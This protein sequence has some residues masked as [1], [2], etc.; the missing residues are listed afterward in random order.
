[1]K[2]ADHVASRLPFIDALKALASQ[3]IV[4]H[5]LA[6]YGPM[7]D[8]VIPLAPALVSWFADYARLAV[9]AFLVIAGFLGASALASQFSE[10]RCENSGRSRFPGAG[11][12]APALE[13]GAPPI[14][15]AEPLTVRRLAL[16][17]ALRYRRLALPLVAAVALAILAAGIVRPW[18]QHPSVPAA[19]TLAQLIA[20][21][22]L[23]HDVVGEEALSA[24]IWYVAIDLQ[25]FGLLL[26]ALWVGR[27]LRA[28][29]LPVFVLGVASLFVF[30]LDARWDV[31][32]PYFFGAYS[33]G[34]FAWHAQAAARVPLSAVL[35]ALAA[36]IALALEF[37]LRIAVALTIATLL[38]MAGR[39]GVLQ[40]W[41]RGRMVEMLGRI[42]YS[43]FLVHFPVCLLVNA[44]FVQFAGAHPFVNL[45]GV[46]LAWAT[47][48]A[49]GA[50]FYQWVERPLQR[51]MGA[52]SGGRTA[53]GARSA[54]REL[55]RAWT[56]RWTR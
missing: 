35:L 23:V 27:H 11:R 24:G 49:A 40:R 9:Q 8:A 6:F 14:V 37:R 39:T 50:L 30:N 52:R 4:L 1:V 51:S 45:A 12:P 16:A 10:V 48:I 32:A 2:V 18:M 46:A 7:S 38:A 47:S 36:L 19:P 33:L 31:W 56:A 54:A 34:V 55:P 13:P 26:L 28:P 15:V 29:W 42:S 44:A 3:L 43:I 17:F 41:P 53:G 21:A 20:H 25:L 5:H 22:L